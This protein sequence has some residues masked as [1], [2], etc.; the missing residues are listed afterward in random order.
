MGRFGDIRHDIVQA[1]DGEECET[2]CNMF[3]FA[4]FI[5]LE[6]NLH[7]TYYL[8]CYDL[9]TVATFCVTV[10]NDMMLRSRAKN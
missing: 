3:K 6:S 2:C 4:K 8:Y 9:C 5:H 1:G 7:L 10:V